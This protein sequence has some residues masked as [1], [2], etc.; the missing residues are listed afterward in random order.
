MGGRSWI[1]EPLASSFLP[2]T[3]RLGLFRSPTNANGPRTM[4]GPLVVVEL[5]GPRRRPGEVVDQE[6][7]VGGAAEPCDA[8]G[9]PEIR[10][11]DLK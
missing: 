7:L 6:Q 5:I 8:S 3:T 2:G 9:D 10:R 11:C 4:R 1:L